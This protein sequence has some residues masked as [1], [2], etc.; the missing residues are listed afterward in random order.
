MMEEFYKIEKGA[1]GDYD[2]LEKRTELIQEMMK[3]AAKWK[4]WFVVWGAGRRMNP[5]Y[6]LMFF[7]NISWRPNSHYKQPDCWEFF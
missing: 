6:T 4:I 2:R 7:L 5:L 1:G 3:S